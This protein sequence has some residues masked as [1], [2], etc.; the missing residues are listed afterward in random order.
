MTAA[1]VGPLRTGV[2]HFQRG[3]R[4]ANGGVVAYDPPVNTL[5]PRYIACTDHHVACDCREAEFS[6][7]RN[8]W[9]MERASLRSAIDRILDDHPTD[10]DEP[11]MCTGC[12]IAR[13]VHVYPRGH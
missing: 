13:A 10:A 11:C 1:L 7:E 4:R 6:E 3:I 2:I 9:R 12:Q 8:E 5:D